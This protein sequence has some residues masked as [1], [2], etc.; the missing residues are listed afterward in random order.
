VANAQH[1]NSSQDHG[2]PVE[3]VE[4]TRYALGS[5]G[6][7]PCSDAYWN[8][9][10]VKADLFWSKADDGLRRPWSGPVICNPPGGESEQ[11]KT[12]GKRRV[13][14]PSL[15][16]P[17]WERLVE[18]WRRGAIDGAVWVSFSLE[19]LV[20]LQGSPAH[21]AQFP[22]I[23]PCERL[24]FL[25]RPADG[26]PPK[27]GNQPTHGNALSLLPSRRDPGLAKLQLRRF[28]ERGAALGAVVRPF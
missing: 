14:V 8:H 16:R 20:L 4:L 15:V 22:T 2:T 21:P 6:T 17:F 13:L 7:D 27:P 10:S 23:I 12:T 26:G 9:H 5:I 11:D 28:A 18:D 25:R 24:C 1:S 3:V 19:Q